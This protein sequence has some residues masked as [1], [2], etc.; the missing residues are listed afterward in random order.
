MEINFLRN[1][2]DKKKKNQARE[3]G[4]TEWKSLQADAWAEHIVQVLCNHD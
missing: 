2:D 4:E 1:K 3:K